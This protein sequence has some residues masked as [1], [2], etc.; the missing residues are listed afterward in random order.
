MASQRKKVLVDFADNSLI[1]MLESTSTFVSVLS[2]Y[3]LTQFNQ[4][5]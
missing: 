4:N 2:G 1:G 3:V 5:R